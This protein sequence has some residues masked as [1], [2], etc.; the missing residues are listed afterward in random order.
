MGTLLRALLCR[1]PQGALFAQRPMPVYE[2]LCRRCQRT[3]S[4]LVGMTADSHAMRCPHCNSEDLVRLV[5]KFSRM[6][7]DEARI[8]SLLDEVDGAS[9]SDME[10]LFREAGN[11]VDDPGLSD[12]LIEHYQTS[13]DNLA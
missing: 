11:I 8:D 7:T 6:R 1:T 2:T 3:S 12:D 5:S 10:S 4:H 13:D 9:P